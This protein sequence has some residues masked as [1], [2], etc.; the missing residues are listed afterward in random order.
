MLDCNGERRRP[1]MTACWDDRAL[2]R[3]GNHSI[4]VVIWIH[5]EK[6]SIVWL[7]RNSVSALFLNKVSTKF[8]TNTVTLEIRVLPVFPLCLFFI[9]PDIIIISQWQNQE[10][11]I[12]Y[13]LPT[14]RDTEK[15]PVRAE[16]PDAKE[17]TDSSESTESTWSVKYSANEQL[18][19]DSRSTVKQWTFL[20]EYKAE[21][22]VYLFL[23][24]YQDTTITLLTVGSNSYTFIC[25]SRDWE[26]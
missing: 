15:V 19:W 1:Y 13:T 26:K 7:E 6:Q 22:L 5:F 18:I 12:S 14:L 3:D 17:V 16:S 2:Y 21:K 9:L 11:P 10:S 24:I 8:N 25:G 4:H 20:I 23:P